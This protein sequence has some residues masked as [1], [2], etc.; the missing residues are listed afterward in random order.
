[1]N[2]VRRSFESRILAAAFNG[3]P[4]RA[5]S[6]ACRLRYWGD[7]VL[8]LANHVGAVVRLFQLRLIDLELEFIRA[9][10]FAIGVSTA[11]S[12]V[13]NTLSPRYPDSGL[14]PTAC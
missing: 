13:T 3:C 1:M 10:I 6:S 8:V 4:A 14:G 11:P 9:R 2:P 5:D 7:I 12:Q